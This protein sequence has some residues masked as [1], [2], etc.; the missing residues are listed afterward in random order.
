MSHKSSCNEKLTDKEIWCSVA[1][2][3]CGVRLL[4][5]DLLEVIKRRKGSDETTSLEQ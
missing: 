5:K 1:C 4:G 3:C 2:V